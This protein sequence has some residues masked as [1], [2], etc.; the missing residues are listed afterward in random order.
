[1]Q[2]SVGNASNATAEIAAANHFPAI[3]LFTAPRHYNATAEMSPQSSFSANPSQP[4]SVASAASI[5]GPWGTNFSA[6]CWFHGRDLHV[7]HGFPVGLVSVNWGATD[8]STWMP[9]AAYASCNATAPAERNIGAS[10]MNED[11]AHRAI[12]APSAGGAACGRIGAPCTQSSPASGRSPQC[13]SGRCF[14]YGR[15]PNWVLPK[16]AGAVGGWCDEESPSNRPS[17]LFNQMISPLLPMTIAGAVWYQGESDAMSGHTVRSLYNCRF[18]AMIAAWRSEWHAATHGQTDSAFPFGFV[19]IS[20]WEA[21]TPDAT[22]ADDHWAV[23]RAAQS[24][25]LQ[26]PNT[27]MA[28]AIDLGAF[29]GGCCG[30]L[31][32]CDTFPNLC[33]HPQWKQEVGRRLSLGARALAYGEKDLCWRGPTAKAATFLTRLP[34]APEPSSASD[35]NAPK[36]AGSGGAPAVVV[37]FDVCTSSASEFLPPKLSIRNTTD[38]DVQLADSAG[39]LA[40]VQATIVSATADAVTVQPKPAATAAVFG[41]GA[42]NAGSY[43]AAVAVRYLWSQSPCAH[44]HIVGGPQLQGNCS[45][46]DAN[47]L[48][49]PPF[50]LN[51]SAA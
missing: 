13:C 26:L 31:N 21:P 16:G 27:F 19:Q 44:P 14:Y 2:F 35:A 12:S 36:L 17:G 33:I 1:M 40:W 43:L 6:A 9:A 48:P 42:A 38:F 51:V 11:L 8:V 7:A 47:N 50:M 28:V 30:G 5:G 32:D 3:R 4:W 25:A 45:V 37:H 22:K 23:V 41:K 24:E 49:A 15:G 18:E 34:S 20:S 39:K 10:R 46:Y 29:M